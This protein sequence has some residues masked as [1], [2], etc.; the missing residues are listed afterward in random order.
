MAGFKSPATDPASP[1]YKDV[2][3]AT[4]HP[5]AYPRFSDIPP[6][7]TDVRPVTAW[8][9][10]VADIRHDKARLDDGIT[11]MP[12]AATDTEAFAANARSQINVPGAEPP[13]PAAADESQAYADSLRKRAT[14]PPKRKAP[15]R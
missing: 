13:A 12:P 10:A 14:P 7:P 4:Q 8:A 15:Q 11:A 2:M 1:V 9:V 6:A 5:G 3:Y